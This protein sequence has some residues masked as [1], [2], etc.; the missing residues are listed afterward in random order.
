MLGDK[1]VGANEHASKGKSTPE[2]RKDFNVQFGMTK[3]EQGE[4][5]ERVSHGLNP[6]KSSPGEMT[7]EP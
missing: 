4:G 2:T 5:K 3:L 1:E 7:T 6:G